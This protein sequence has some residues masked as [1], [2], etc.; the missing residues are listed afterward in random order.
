MQTNVGMSGKTVVVGLNW[1]VITKSGPGRKKDIRK[2]CVDSGLTLGAMVEGRELAAIGLCAK[3][4]EF[5]SGAAMV[6][7]ANSL[8]LKE[9][10]FGDTKTGANWILVEKVKSGER[11]D[12][13]WMCAVSDGVPIPGSDIIEDLTVTSAKLAEFIE[14]LENV[15]IFSTDEEILSYVGDAR[16]SIVKGFAELTEKVSLSKSMR[17]QK[18]VG[19]PDLVYIVIFIVAGL[20][21]AG[22]ALTWYTEQQAQEAKLRQANTIKAQNARNEQEE[23]LRRTREYQQADALA[24]NAELLKVTAA[25]SKKPSDVFSA[26]SQAINSLPLNHGGWNMESLSCNLASCTVVLARNENVGTF[27]SLRSIIPSVEFTEAGGASYTLPLQM[28]RDRV[29]ALTSLKNWQDFAFKE[30][31]ALQ[32]MKMSGMVSAALGQRQEL[33]YRPPQLPTSGNANGVA[34]TQTVVAGAVTGTA[35]NQQQAKPLGLASG[36]IT[37]TGTSLWQLDHV[38]EYLMS[39]E[40]AMTGLNVVFGKSLSMDAGWTANGNYYLLSANA[41]KPTVAVQPSKPAG[42][43]APG[44]GPTPPVNQPLPVAQAQQNQPKK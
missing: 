13:Y 5:P 42:I 8:V 16:P 27:G 20:V 37:I 7:A 24:R 31:I 2:A 30:G 18:I 15:E 12:M 44:V 23:I 9:R 35:P 6:A 3:K 1:S 34:V 4:A 29:V 10:D 33:T 26:W 19:I 43:I 25:L 40:F 36:V 11:S 38:G 22:V 41:A 28:G 17:P 32:Q 21:V 14:I 39:N